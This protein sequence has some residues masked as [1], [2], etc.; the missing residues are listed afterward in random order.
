MAFRMAASPVASRRRGVAGL[1]RLLLTTSMLGCAVLVPAGAG[2][3][4]TAPATAAE[5][6]AFAIPAQPL[7]AAI[8]AF[9]GASGWQ[10]SYSSALVAGK[11][12]AA[13]SGSMTAEEALRRLVSGSGISV[14]IS[15]PGSAALFAGAG[16]AA[17]E[18]VLDPL[19]VE[20]GRR[21]GRNDPAT[22]TTGYVA[23]NGSLATKTD[24]PVIEVP[25]SLSIVTRQE[26]DDR[27]VTDLNDAIAY[28]PGIRAIDYPGG[29]G[30]PLMYLRGFRAQSQRDFYR[31]GLRN[32]YNPYDSFVEPYGLENVAVLRGPASVLYGDAAPGGLVSMTTKR[33]TEDPFGEIRLDYGSFDRKQVAIDLGGPLDE[34][35]HILYRLT[36]L[37]RDADTQI[38][39][40]RDDSVYIAPALTLDS[41][42]G[43]R[44]TLLA[45]YQNWTQGGAEQSLP[46]DNSVY[47]NGIKIPSD[48]YMG[49][50]GLSDWEVESSTIGY[51]VEQEIDDTWTFRNNLRYTHAELDYVSASNRAWPIAVVDGHYVNVGVQKRPRTSDTLVAD[52]NVNGVVE[53]GPLA[54]DL[55][56]GVNYGYSRIRETR[57]NSTNYAHIDILNPVYDF[58]PVYGAPWTDNKSI[59]RQIGIYAQDQIRIDNWVLTLNG[60]QDWAEGSEYEYTGTP[61]VDKASSHAFTGRVGAAYLF[62][63]G[64]APYIAYSTS[65][66]PLTGRDFDKKPFEPTTGEQYEAGVKYQPR[67]MNLLVTASVFQ[68]T[69]QNVLTTDQQHSGYSVQEGEVRSR[70]LEL[71][72]KGDLGDGWSL[73]AS[74]AYTD[75]EVTKDNPNASGISKVG[76]RT[77][78]VPYHTAGLWV[79]HD[80]QT[81]ALA[82]LRI[83]A[84]LRYVGSSVTAM[85]TGTGTQAEID[86]YTL[87]DASASYDLSQVHPGLAGLS[88]GVSGT[89]LTDE[90]YY[91]PGFY[92]NSVLAGK[93]RAI[94]GNLTYRW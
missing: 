85:D 21:G 58:D 26:M 82:G 24:T 79:N 30:M 67:G 28:A 9:I 73:V 63:N 83:G 84:G 60:R 93:R 17:G 68:L 5:T 14:R 31:D 62:E 39:H 43:T 7:A 94:K 42:E 48:F 33:P 61:D 57:T 41:R 65:F 54:H 92:S 38:D 78:A 25:Q 66:E 77:Q 49:I 2:A 50:P 6:R 23:R 20:A 47:S 4:Q 89:N 72:A 91:T 35:R 16:A 40:S 15:A 69:Q 88:L 8:D 3:Q 51:A 86:G 80:F 11:T 70:G 19:M 36:A 55:T 90:E 18:T 12:S 75:S 29:Q 71:E 34:D 37:K 87:F 59:I 52:A 32:G 56:F 46:L 44:L 13:V 74:Y 27:G 76:T 1:T 10:I 22:A 64:F 81:A 53:T 45:Q